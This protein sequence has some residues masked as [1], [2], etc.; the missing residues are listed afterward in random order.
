MQQSSEDQPAGLSESTAPPP[1]LADPPQRQPWALAGY[2][3]P[4]T[5]EKPPS[6]PIEPTPPNFGG[7][8]LMGFFLEDKNLF[9]EEWGQTPA[10]SPSE[11][12]DAARQRAQNHK[13]I[14]KTIPLYEQQSGGSHAA[15]FAT[16]I[17]PRTHLSDIQA[18]QETTET[19]ERNQ[20]SLG[21]K[22]R[23]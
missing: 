23:R 17:W 1:T 20:H 19:R 18:D 22:Q 5:T 14:K 7:S 11:D 12:S 15:E 2:A 16:T 10:H 3:L 6:A 21:P 4:P 13:S 9:R 8:L